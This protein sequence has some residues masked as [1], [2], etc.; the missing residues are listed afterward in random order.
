MNLQG[1]VAIITGGA[2]GIGRATALKFKAEG[3]EAVVVADLNEAG[4]I[5]VA[6]QIG[7]MGMRCDVGR[8]ADIQELV[9]ATEK[10]YGRVDVY[11][12]NAG[13]GP[14]RRSRGHRRG[15]GPDV[16]HPRHG[17]HLGGPCGGR[18]DGSTAVAAHS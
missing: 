2:S 11:F 5:Q 18:A 3:A 8:E 16:A 7:G 13:I 9:R 4:A 17:A 15:L 12:S 1:K 14:W 6:E 10:R